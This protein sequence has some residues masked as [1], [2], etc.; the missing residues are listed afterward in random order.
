MVLDGRSTNAA[1]LLPPRMVLGTGAAWS[2]VNLSELESRS[3][4]WKAS[5]DLQDSFYQFRSDQLAEDFAFD[6]PERAGDAG[7]SHVWEDGC[8]VEVEPHEWV[9][10][11]FACIPPG[12]SWA[13]WTVQA[14]VAHV[15]N[16]VRLP[17]EP[18][19]VEDRRV[20]PKL[21]AT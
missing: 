15:L 1:H 12:W 17:G 18:P 7:V 21:S 8:L 14:V 9:Y 5:G 13:M 2:D 4:L 20:A 19:L 11:C 16:S 10:N 3:P 6:F